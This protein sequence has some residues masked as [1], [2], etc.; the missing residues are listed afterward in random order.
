MTRIA[1]YVDST[2]VRA[3]AEQQYHRLAPVAKDG[4]RQA[5]TS[6]RHAAAAVAPYAWTARDTAAHY[7]DEAR[8]RL[9]PRVAGAVD[10]AREALPPKVEHAVDTAAKRTR[11]TV[12]QATDYTV[13]RV[14]NAVVTA[15]I[16]AEPVAEEAVARGAAAVA[17]LRGH[18][19]VADIEKLARKRMRRARAGRVAKRLTVLGIVAGGGYAAWM[20]WTR[21]TN[22]DWLVEAPEPTEVSGRENGVA[23]SH[24][25]HQSVDGSRSVFTDPEV[26]A[27]QAEAEAE[28][29]KRSGKR[30]GESPA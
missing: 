21:Q 29:A 11:T 23:Q 13:P 2:G 22:P 9:A 17:A 1:D 15:R 14:E 12:R 8:H 20:W 18:V 6:A 5:R 25:S 16:A 19:T 28:A 27:K 24:G 3:A 4:A 7:A 10:H 30:D 26:Q